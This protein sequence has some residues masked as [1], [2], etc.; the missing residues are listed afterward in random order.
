M[1]ALTARV[2]I[3]RQYTRK[4]QMRNSFYTPGEEGGGERSDFFSGRPYVRTILGMSFWPLNVGG[5]CVFVYE[6]LGARRW[7]GIVKRHLSYTYNGGLDMI[8]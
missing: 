6:K 3:F 7:N 8:M 4:S 2:T 1:Q 5:A